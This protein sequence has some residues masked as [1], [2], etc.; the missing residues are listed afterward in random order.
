MVTPLLT[1]KLHVPPQRPD[2][3]GRPHLLQRLDEGLHRKLTLISAPAG[4]GKT[5]LVVEWA[6]ACGR[7]VAW[8]SLDEGDNDPVHFLSYLVA[9]LQTVAPGAGQG[10][11]ETL[12]ASGPSAARAVLTELINEVGA[13]PESIILVLDDYHVVDNR[14][15]HQA[16]SFLLD[17][18]PDNLHLVIASRADPPLPIPRLRGRGELTELRQGDLCFDEGEAARFLNRVVGLDLSAGDVAILAART[19]GWIAGLQMAALAL[20]TPV[21]APDGTAPVSGDQRPAGTFIQAFA[22]SDRYIMDYLVEEVLQRQPA[23]IQAFLLRTCVLEQLTAPLCDALLQD[24]QGEAGRQ[25]ERPPIPIHQPAGPPLDNSQ[26]LLEHLDAANLFI[27]PLDHERRWYR[28]HRLFADLLRRRLR[29]T[30]PKLVPVLHRRASAWHEARAVASGRAGAMAPAIDH[31]LAAGD[32]ARAADLIEGVAEETLM[33]SEVITYL[34][35][36]KALP[37]DLVQARP[38]LGLY[39]AWALLLAA[40]PLDAVESRLQTMAGEAEVS[41]DRIAPLRAF[42]AMFQGRIPRAAELSRRALENLPE[43]D[44]FLRSIAAWNLGM[45]LVL[46]GDPDGGGEALAQA[47]RTSRQ[48]GN[49][50]IAVMALCNLAELQMAQGRLQQAWQTYEQAL[51]TAVDARGRA[52]PIGGMARIGL[53]EIK[54]E[55]NELDEARHH[56][57]AGI[58]QAR[59]WGEI[60]NLDGYIALARVMHAEGDWPGARK[61]LETARQLAIQFDATDLDDLLVEIQQSRLWLAQG[62]VDKARH[63]LEARGVPPA[64][65]LPPEKIENIFDYHLQKYERIVAARIELAQGQPES[66]LA[67]LDPLL[68]LMER[69]GLSSRRMIEIYNLRALA[70]QAQGREKEALGSLERA[71]SL[72]GPGGFV[73]SFVD[74]GQPMA[75]LLRLAATHGIRPEYASDLLSAFE[76]PDLDRPAAATAQPL[77]EPLSERE[78]EVLQLLSTSLS[79]PEIADR[80]F[81]ATSTVRSHVKNIYGKLNVHRRWD[82]VERGRE[83]GLIR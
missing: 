66:A 76:T 75:A 72:G 42:V 80:L 23:D 36:V 16:L 18:L 6:A 59:L 9:A 25:P 53:G 22:G 64:H 62:D 12:H 46:E 48:A 33:R 56:L 45:T 78:L 11:L 15:V 49:V 58:E 74:E 3:V 8:L 70:L 13:R 38:S 5:T 10:L 28:Y 68:A 63:W 55:W 77:I 1:T 54:R 69:R 30:D 41:D 61:M 34:G 43:E 81:I 24:P 60:G 39:H 20:Q 51:E 83:L 29:Q 14:R 7:P 27:V 17:H 50:M 82:A 52:L 73:R 31:A 71:L 79:S 44:L 32:V 47:A 2:L 21:P 26:A 4:F 57:E 65:L 67:M 37:E 40:Q 35:W 19:E